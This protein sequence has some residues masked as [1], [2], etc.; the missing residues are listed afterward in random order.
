MIIMG[1]DPGS[2]VTGFG[3]IDSNPKT[4]L[5]NYITS[6][7]IRLKAG[8]LPGRL[9]VLYEDLNSLCHEYRPEVMIIESL[10]VKINWNT[11]LILGHARGVILLVA[12]QHACEIRELQPRSVKKAITG[13]GGS[14]KQ[15]VS[16]MVSQRLGITQTLRVDASDAL[17][18]ALCYLT[19]FSDTIKN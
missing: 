15:V 14:S 5:V 2:L 19:L 4:G 1:I 13:N 7:T 6:G 9:H 11:A 10:F 18:L 3:I 16:F 12:Q 17:A 8:P